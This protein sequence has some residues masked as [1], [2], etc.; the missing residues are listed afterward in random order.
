MLSSD[1]E[2]RHVEADLRVSFGEGLR[3]LITGY[4][5]VFNVMSVNL[6][7]FREIIRPDAVTR[8]LDEKIDVRAFIDHDTGKIIGRLSAKTLRLKV[9]DKGLRAEID[10]PNTGP[11]RD[12]VESIGRGDISGMSFAFRVMPD[13][14]DW[15]MIDEM[16]V[17]EVFDMRILEVSPVSLP[18]YPQTEVEV[19]KRSAGVD[20][21]LASL[22][23]WKVSEPWH[24]DVDP[25]CGARTALTILEARQRQARG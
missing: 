4:P 23:R 19:G 14:D 1:I 5:I 11:A 25:G 2:T 6:G 17:R 9:D 24:F 22:A 15:K 3:A 8:T 20:A 7:G 18:A 21:A 12:V 16:P 10:P 13:G